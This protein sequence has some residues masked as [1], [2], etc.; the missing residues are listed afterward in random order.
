MI[1]FYDTM[2][3]VRELNNFRFLDFL[4]WVQLSQITF[5]Y[6]ESL[7]IMIEVEDRESD[8]DL[9][10]YFTSLVY[11]CLKFRRKRDTNTSTMLMC[12][13]QCLI[14]AKCFI[15]VSHYC[16]YFVEWYY[17]KVMLVLESVFASRIDFIFIIPAMLYNNF[18]SKMK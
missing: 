4:K 1:L 10:Y 2:D 12:L 8:W 3:Y 5:Y 16:W 13:A 17:C 9:V 6:K 18:T 7:R 14:F 15:I 11:S